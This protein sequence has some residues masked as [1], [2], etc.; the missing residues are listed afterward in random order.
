MRISVSL[1]ILCAGLTG[2]STTTNLFLSDE[3]SVTS[4]PPSSAVRLNGKPV[5]R[6]PTTLTLDRTQNYE[7]EV[8]KNSYT[9]E[10][11]V[12]K[13]SLITTREGIEFG[14]PST[15]N[16][17]LRK[18]PGENEAIVPAGDV[19]EFKN[20][21]RKA[22]G[23]SEL[24]ASVRADIAGAREAATKIKATFAAREAASRATIADIRKAIDTAKQAKVTDAAALA[25]L[26]EAEL[27]LKEANSQAEVSRNKAANTLKSIESRRLALESN[28]D[29]PAEARL[30]AEKSAVAQSLATADA[31]LTSATTAHTAAILKSSS[32][33]SFDE[34]IKNLEHSVAHE[35]TSVAAAQANSSAALKALDA[36]T[37][38]LFRIAGQN[39]EVIRKAAQAEA[40]KSLIEIQKALEEQKTAAAKAREER[41]A[42]QTAAAKALAE[43]NKVNASKLADSTKAAD[44]ALAHVRQDAE[45]KLADSAKALIEANKVNAAKLADSTKAAEKA[46]DHARQDADDKL[47]D[48]TKALVEANKVNASKLADSTK[49]AEKALDHARQAADDKL[50]DSTKAAEK[51]LAHARQDAE[52]KLSEVTKALA[53]A[54][55][56]AKKA[57]A[58]ANKIAADN[59]AEGEK[60][61]ADA[62]A[63]GEAKLSEV[64]KAAEKA[65]ADAR[66]DA[67]TK[68]TDA[69][70]ATA[71]F[72]AKAERLAYS[73]FSARYGLLEAKLRAGSITQDQYKEQIAALRKELG[74]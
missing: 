37:E 46:L 56:E 14:F 16:F 70:K 1:L 71:E 25:R 17:N 38:E 55:D 4:N 44:Q 58:E 28:A 57:I 24:Q 34:R 29:Q 31:K 73:E 41:D 48:S 42:A 65:L 66:I 26:A 39:P 11:T 10:S 30:N 72:K 52:A 21:T 22:L 18:I 23:E 59:K 15:V 50:A 64:T 8:G 68:I 27:A 12:L 3:V 6:T 45:S 5:G 7:I 54:Q 47:A 19:V 51:A 33:L 9:A 53:F 2:C 13:P 67:E 61:L 20:L 43:A 35:M 36:R 49:A 32:S 74:L 40:A 63:A 69:T 62:K 60:L